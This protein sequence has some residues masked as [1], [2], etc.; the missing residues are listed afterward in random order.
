MSAVNDMIRLLDEEHRILTEG[1]YAALEEL[2][3][4]KSGLRAALSDTEDRASLDRLARLAT[5]NAALI[6]AA[7]LGFQSA[8]TRLKDIREGRTNAT[9]TREGL[10]QPLARAARRMEQKF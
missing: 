4:R 8:R 2:L 9:Y 1:N 3:R 5:R 7:Q 6:A 10:R